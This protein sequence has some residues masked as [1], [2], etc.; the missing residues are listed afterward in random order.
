MAGLINSRKRLMLLFLGLLGF[1][2]HGQTEPVVPVDMDYATY[3]YDSTLQTNLLSYRYDLWDLDGDQQK[4]TICFTSNGGAH[5]YYH[6]KIGLSSDQ[7][8]TNY[9]SF[10]IDFPHPWEGEIT[11]SFPYFTVRDFDKDGLDEIYLNLDNNYAIVKGNLQKLGINSL[12]VIL[13][14]KDGQLQ[15]REYE[16]PKE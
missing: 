13:D 4:D 11:E 6:L 2:T 14:F 5:A 12:Q 7:S 1:F 9:P 16:K 3:A 10:L 8:W 15:L